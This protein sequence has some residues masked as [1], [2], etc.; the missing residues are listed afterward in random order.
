MLH[1]QICLTFG[2]FTG[3]SDETIRLLDLHKRVELGAL[4]EHSGTIT[5]L[6][7]HG[8]HLL[9]GSEDGQICIFQCG[10]WDCKKT[11]KGH[12]SAVLQV[13]IIIPIF[14]SM[15]SLIIW[16]SFLEPISFLPVSSSSNRSPGPFCGT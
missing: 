15:I 5:S 14:M 13:I 6:S 8:S 2:I 4:M 12:S 1:N 9:S 3:S 7:F 10:S 11:L 16:T